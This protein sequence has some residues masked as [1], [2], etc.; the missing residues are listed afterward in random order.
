MDAD[1][2]V[3]ISAG[4]EDEKS[5]RNAE[6][7][8]T[9]NRTETGSITVDKTLFYNNRPDT[10][11]AGTQFKYRLYADAEATQRAKLPDGS[12]V[13]DAVVTIGRDAGGNA[14]YTA[15]EERGGIM[16]DVEKQYSYLGWGSATFS[17]LAYDTVDSSTSPP[18]RTPKKYYVFELENTGNAETPNWQPI[19]TPTAEFDFGEGKKTYTVVGDNKV[20]VLD[21]EHREQAAA[22]ANSI[23]ELGS[24][25]VTKQVYTTDG[26]ALDESATGKT[27]KVGLFTKDGTSYKLH[28][29]RVLTVTIGQDSDGK[30]LTG[31]DTDG[32]GEATFANLEFDSTGSGTT[33]YVFE[34]DAKNNPI[35]PVTG[36]DASGK[37]GDDY[38]V[39]YPHAGAA[40]AFTLTQAQHVFDGT[41]T[42]QNAPANA[43]AVVKNT[44]LV[45][46]ASF[47]IV[48]VDKQGWI[49]ASDK[50]SA[51][52]LAGAATV[53]ARS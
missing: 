52:K 7:V 18:T 43:G 39:S 15:Q 12:D 13:P 34:V 27:F 3:T 44:A 19:K 5:P 40:T 45:T 30:K 23:K 42:E 29:N 35:I 47:K 10:A 6:L 31:A 36:N 22:F 4:T 32:T 51:P 8:I 9:N 33:Y 11:K 37:L 25:K 53:N 26:S 20:K 14:T 49:D 17:G 50:A 48:K 24:I 46:S 21:H 16:V 41:Y 38:T 28:D 1:T 2:G